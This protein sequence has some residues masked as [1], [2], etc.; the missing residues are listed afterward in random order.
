MEDHENCLNIFDLV[1]SVK[2][3]KNCFTI[4]VGVDFDEC[5]PL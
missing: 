5:L 1:V 4:E 3:H 2:G